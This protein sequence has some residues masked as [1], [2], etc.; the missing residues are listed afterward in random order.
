[1]TTSTTNAGSSAWKASTLR[2]FQTIFLFLLVAQVCHMAYLHQT[3]N[4]TM[5]NMN[6]VLSGS[7]E[8]FV[9]SP[10][11]RTQASDLAESDGSN[12]TSN[13]ISNSSMPP[14]VSDSSNK[15]SKSQNENNATSLA[16]ATQSTVAV[17]SQH[18]ND[19]S[20]NSNM[21]DAEVFSFPHEPDT[22]DV[23]EQS[24]T[25]PQWMKDYFAWHKQER[26]KI[27]QDNWKDFT[28]MVSR[29][30]DVDDRCGGTADRI[31]PAPFLV[32]WAAK[33]KRLLM[34]HWSRPCALEEFLVPP[35]GGI[36]W[37][38]PEWLLPKISGS[39]VAVGAENFPHAIGNRSDT[40]IWTRLQ[41]P[42]AGSLQYRQAGLPGPPF[43]VVY[44]DVWRTLFTPSPPVQELI[45]DEMH[46]MSLVPG[47]YAAVHLRALYAV[48]T[49]PEAMIRDWSEN[50]IAC[51][52]QLRPG[53]PIYFASDS[54]YAVDHLQTWIR[55]TKNQSIR[56]E[57]TQRDH[58]PL[59]VEK[60]PNWQTRQPSEYYDTFVDLY[61]LGLS[62]CLSYSAGG[63]GQWGLWLGYDQSCY[64]RN[65]VTRTPTK[66]NWKDPSGVTGGTD[67][68]TAH[69]YSGDGNQDTDSVVGDLMLPPMG[70][71]NIIDNNNGNSESTLPAKTRM[72][73]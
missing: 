17:P 18:V 13:N 45:R 65:L 19:G 42:N 4:L 72:R 5:G 21:T 37:R 26:A 51:G 70:S 64:N 10:K 54:K 56:V 63:Y 71:M 20:N 3:G 52:T 29:C 69:G 27:T 43:D 16:T 11:V 32:Y 40:A 49:R 15:V 36:D 23:W 44:R 24:T 58:E 55:D 31:K 9:Q 46:K 57:S 22:T 47:E 48:K 35:Q 62:K 68:A 2:V 14:P 34:Y 39:F 61:I 12:T 60:S 7:L 28:Y 25:L 41:S 50:A 1:M 6:Q 8:E 33:T 66:C 53:G 67:N 30:L 73:R 59:H 38:V